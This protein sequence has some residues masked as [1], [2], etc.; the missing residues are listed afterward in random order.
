M[1]LPGRKTSTTISREIRQHFDNG[2]LEQWCR[3]N[4]D[5]I[6]HRQSGWCATVKRYSSAR[7]FMGCHADIDTCDNYIYVREGYRLICKLQFTQSISRGLS[8]AI[9][10]IY[11]ER[12]CKK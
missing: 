1:S 2:T 7:G 8:T 3:E 6:I 5:N 4:L 10:L 12:T 9:R 11:K